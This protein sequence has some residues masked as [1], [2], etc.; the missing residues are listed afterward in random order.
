VQPKVIFFENVKG[1]T[2]K[3]EKNR[4]EGKKYSEYVMSCLSLS[5]DDFI[6]YNVT[7]EL[8]DFSHYGLPQKRTRF[9]LV[10][11]RKD[12]CSNSVIQSSQ[13]F[14][15]I[16]NNKEQFLLSKGLTVNT[17]LEDAISDLLMSNGKVNSPDSKGFQSGKYIPPQSAYQSFLREG[18]SDSM[19]ADSHRFANHNAGTTELFELLLKYAKP[20]TKIE[21][22]L[23]TRFNVKKRNLT[24]LSPV[25]VTPTLTSHP[26]D[27]VH[28]KEPRILTVREYAR[29]QSFPDW[30]EI[31]GKYTTGGKLRKKEVPRYTQLGNAIPPLFGEL[32]GIALQEMAV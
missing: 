27:Y 18:C 6:G 15:K 2:Q 12:I 29:I 20:G 24:V 13:F 9:I 8:V 23:K 5:G 3:F 4:T 31:K 14:E 25:M 22:E 17:C 16:E 30:Y 1:F 7:A 19:I 10:G 32:A 11:I 28:Y 21:G 26:D